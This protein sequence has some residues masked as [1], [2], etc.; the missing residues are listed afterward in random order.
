MHCR[1]L[2]LLLLLLLIRHAWKVADLNAIRSR[3]RGRTWMF[4]S[5]AA[6]SRTV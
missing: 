5:A 6:S 2:S 3:Y 4:A 1:W